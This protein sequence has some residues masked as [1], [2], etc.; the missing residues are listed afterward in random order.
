MHELFAMPDDIQVSFFFH[1][2]ETRKDAHISF[3]VKD[4]ID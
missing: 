4:W 2:I 1:V 3:S